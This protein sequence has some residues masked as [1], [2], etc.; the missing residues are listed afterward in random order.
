[1]YKNNGYTL[2]DLKLTKEMDQDFRCSNQYK[3]DKAT[4]TMLR[5][6]DHGLMVTI[7]FAGVISKAE[8]ITCLNKLLYFVNHEVFGKNYEDEGNFLN[9]IAVY[10]EQMNGR[11]HYHIQIEQ[12]DELDDYSIQELNDLFEQKSKKIKLD[13]PR[14]KQKDINGCNYTCDAFGRNA[15]HIVE[16]NNPDGMAGYLSK[17]L[18]KYNNSSYS[19]LSKDGATFILETGYRTYN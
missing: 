13:N 6:A 9:G 3:L 11:P 19:P 10:E 15:V 14:Y 7:T 12:C 1:M 2:S 16:L 8:S 5:S 4:K 17:D 18:S